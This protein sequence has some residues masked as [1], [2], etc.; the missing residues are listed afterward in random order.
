M[1]AL[2]ALSYWKIARLGTRAARA[3]QSPSNFKTGALD[4]AA[5]IEIDG[6]GRE[7]WTKWIRVP[8]SKNDL[9]FVT[10]TAI[11]T[12]NFTPEI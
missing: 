4:R 3:G 11:M 5:V 2:F 10:S 12:A 6:F 9:S 7:R 8:C 1:G